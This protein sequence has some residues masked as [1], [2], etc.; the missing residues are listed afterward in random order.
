MALV[1]FLEALD[2]LHFEWDLP[3]SGR[4]VVI[5]PTRGCGEIFFVYKSVFVFSKSKFRASVVL[6][7]FSDVLLVFYVHFFFSGVS[8]AIRIPE[9]RPRL[10]ITGSRTRF[11]TMLSRRFGHDD[12]VC[13]AY[14]MIA[15]THDA[16]ARVLRSGARTRSTLTVIIIIIIIVGN[17]RSNIFIGSILTGRARAPAHTRAP[18]PRGI[19]P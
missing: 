9:N 7:R 3:G 14:I 12:N 10:R 5:I 18:D 2:S 8:V 16:Y 1:L 19:D 6:T 11:T 15:R 4:I 13:I 17:N